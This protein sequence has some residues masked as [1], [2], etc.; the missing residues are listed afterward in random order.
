MRRYLWVEY[1]GRRFNVAENGG[2]PLCEMF[3]AVTHEE[4]FETATESDYSCETKEEV[5]AYIKSVVDDKTWTVRINVPFHVE[6]SGIR[7]KDASEAKRL[8]G[9][10]MEDV[11]GR[12]VIK[13]EHARRKLA[14]A[15]VSNIIYDRNSMTAQPVK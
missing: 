15:S 10:F 3:Y 8:A 9:C 11:M 13:N 4:H 7:A 5:V 2:Q 14:S 6:I 12:Q 1:K